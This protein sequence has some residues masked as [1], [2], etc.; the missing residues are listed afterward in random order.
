ML[1]NVDH[2]ITSAVQYMYYVMLDYSTDCVLID[3][4]TVYQI[5]YLAMDHG[6]GRGE[7]SHMVRARLVHGDSLLVFC[8][9]LPSD[10]RVP[11]RPALRPNAVEYRL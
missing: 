4:V 6:R 2:T 11:V 5:N 9:L 10:R 8:V 1:R 7:G 3:T